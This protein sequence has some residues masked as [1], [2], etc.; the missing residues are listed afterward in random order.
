MRNVRNDLMA[1]ALKTF[2]GGL[3]YLLPNFSNFDVMPSAA[4]GRAIPAMLVVQNTAY[5]AAYCG[6]VLAAAAAIFSQ[7][8]LK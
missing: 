1:P 8:N 2:L 7:R 4:H 6:I 3:S 5:A